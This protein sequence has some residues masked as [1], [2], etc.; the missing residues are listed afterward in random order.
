[1][2][3]YQGGRNCS[4]NGR[5]RLGGP[6]HTSVLGRRMQKY[7]VDLGCEVIYHRPRRNEIRVPKVRVDTAEV[8]RTKW[9]AKR[10]DWVQKGVPLLEVES[11]KGHPGARIRG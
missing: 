9:L 1:M 2:N 6:S 3:Q 7:A 5:P 4:V 8:V 11:E 10:A